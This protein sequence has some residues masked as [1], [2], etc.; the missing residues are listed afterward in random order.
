MAILSVNDNDECEYTC[1]A[2]NS[3]GEKACSA[4]LHLIETPAG[5]KSQ[6]YVQ[7]SFPFENSLFCCY[8]TE[9]IAPSFIRKLRNCTVLEGQR[10]KFD[11]FIT[12]QPSPTIRWL[13]NGS[14]LDTESNKNKYTSELQPNGKVTLSIDDCVQ[15]DAGEITIIAENRAGSTQCSAELVVE[16]K[17]CFSCR[18]LRDYLGFV[19]AYNESSRSKRRVSFDVPDAPSSTGRQGA[20]PLPPSRLLL[21]PHSKSSLNLSWDHSPSHT[22][23]QPCTYIVEIRDPRTYSWSTYLTALPGLSFSFSFDGVSWI[24]W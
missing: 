22:R 12:G 23:A 16:R 6:P 19:L 17:C 9:D 15:E 18:E 3:V 24:V 2:E 14:P 10:A 11:C 20:I 21:T 1:R 13:L 4:N 8:R 7:S 5:S